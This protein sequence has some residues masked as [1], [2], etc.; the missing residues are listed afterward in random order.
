M[1]SEIIKC[2]LSII[3]SLTCTIGKLPHEPEVNLIS[4]KT[5]WHYKTNTRPSVLVNN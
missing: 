3:S 4:N 5:S 2:H 1:L